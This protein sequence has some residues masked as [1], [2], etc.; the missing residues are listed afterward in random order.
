ML[1]NYPS[2]NLQSISEVEKLFGS[3][4]WCFGTKTHH[5]WGHTIPDNWTLGVS[6]ISVSHIFLEPF[7]LAVLIRPNTVV[8]LTNVKQ[9]VLGNIKCCTCYS[10]QSFCSLSSNTASEKL[11][12]VR[13]LTNNLYQAT[14]SFH[15]LP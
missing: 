1:L 9:P 12:T 11:K 14:T 8:S 7:A 3:L 4:N 10:N 5:L 6:V 15:V 13:L 2:R